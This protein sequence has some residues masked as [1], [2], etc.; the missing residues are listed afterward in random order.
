MIT[1]L[2]ANLRPPNED[3]RLAELIVKEIKKFS[4]SGKGWLHRAWRLL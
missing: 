3:G 1:R 4:N 2:H